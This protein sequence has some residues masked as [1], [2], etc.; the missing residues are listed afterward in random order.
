[1]KIIYSIVLICWAGLS[2]SGQVYIYG[3]ISDESS[4]P[5]FGVNVY[6]K[7]TYDGTS[8]NEEGQFGF[9]ANSSGDQII[10]AS[11]IGYK[12]FEYQVVLSQD[13]IKVDIVL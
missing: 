13:S 4:D 10:M 3:I 2:A 6:V 8:T 5:L 7:G 11:F 1:M 12:A 9:I